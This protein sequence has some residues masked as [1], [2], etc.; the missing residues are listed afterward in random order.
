MSNPLSLA[1]TP[2]VPWVLPQECLVRLGDRVERGQILG[3]LVDRELRVQLTLLKAEAESDI[4]IRLAESRRNELT[5]KL[6][7]IE[8]LRTKVHG[9]A[10]EEEYDPSGSRLKPRGL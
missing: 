1:A 5:Q 2:P 8:K 7:R 9:Y 4:A 6:A 3:R 10:S